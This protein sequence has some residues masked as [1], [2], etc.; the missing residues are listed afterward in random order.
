MNF[1]VIIRGPLGCGKSTLSKRLSK[2]LKAKYMSIDMVLDENNLAKDVEDGYISEKSFLKVNEI[3]FPIIKSFLQKSIPV[4]IDGNFYRKSQVEDL[5]KRLDF[6]HYTFTLKAPLEV[7]INRDKLRKKVHGKDAAQ[8]V[9]KKAVEFDCGIVIDV[10][11][12]LDSCVKDILS[13]L[14]KPSNKPI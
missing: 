3:V 2:I 4:V 8:A 12:D 1:Y 14:P 11:R 10:N 7:C 13:H 5:I 6:P 9:Y